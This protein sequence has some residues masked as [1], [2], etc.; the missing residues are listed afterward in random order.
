MTQQERARAAALERF[1]DAWGEPYD[2]ADETSQTALNQL[3]AEELR[4]LQEKDGGE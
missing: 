1:P 2:P 4:R 3:V